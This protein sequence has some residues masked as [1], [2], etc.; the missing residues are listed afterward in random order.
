[1]NTDARKP[2]PTT[3]AVREQLRKILAST[4]FARAERM[5]RFLEYTVAQMLSGQ[6]SFLK[7]Y[8]IALNVYDKP[9]GFD[10]RLDPIVRVEASRLRAKL[11]E[12]YDTEGHGDAVLISLAKRSYKPQFR[13]AGS[14]ALKTTPRSSLDSEAQRLYLRGRYYWNKRA[15]AALIRAMECFS[16]AVLKKRNFAPAL[17]GLGD[18]YASLAWLESLAPAEAW[19]K[20]IEAAEKALREDASLAGR[21]LTTIACE[22]ALYRWDWEGAESTF[23]DAIAADDRYATAHHWY[24]MFCLAPQR[25]LEEAF[26]EL[27][28]ARDLD[29]A[30]AIISCHLG[31]LLYYRRRYPDA[32]SQLHESIKLDPTLHLAYWHLGFAYAESS[33]FDDAIGAFAKARKLSD[34]PLMVAGLGYIHA[35]SED[36]AK[37]QEA[38]ARLRQ[39][40]SHAYVSAI[41]FAL[42]E[43]ALGNV[44]NAF[45]HLRQAMTERSPRV[46]HLKVEPVF[47]ALKTDGR[48]LTLLEELRIAD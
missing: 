45:Q 19:P 31:L 16:A 14:P 47:D 41:G 13:F 46:A 43:T 5:R 44:D 22:K 9:E 3:A 42:I 24:A 6:G 26:L 15:P 38:A 17:A 20:A 23:R 28:R 1:M 21:A 34:D 2:R 32:V 37:A 4:P 35:L 40:A 11:R 25:R 18:C 27:K 10:P 48:F 36:R 7:E 39:F 30:S 8:S 33:K 12:Y 29:P